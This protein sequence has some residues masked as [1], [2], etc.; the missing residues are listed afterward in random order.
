MPTFWNQRKG[1]GT[2]QHGII[3]KVVQAATAS[4]LSGAG[5]TGLPDE[6]ETMLKR[7]LQPKLPWELLLNQFFQAL[8]GQD[9]SWASAHCR[10][11]DMYLP[12]LQDDDNGLNI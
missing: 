12:S 11:R 7:F 8:S 10:Y 4:K 3:N 1:E 5:E 9:Y 2:G 6:V